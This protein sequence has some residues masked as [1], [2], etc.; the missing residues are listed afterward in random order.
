ME[1]GL[2]E[3]WMKPQVARLFHLQY[4][5]PEKEFAELIDHFYDLPFQKDKCIRIIAREGN[6]IIGFQ[7][8][9]YWPYLY[10]GQVLNSYQSGNSLVHPDHRGKG[11]FQKL[12][13]YL[14]IH[15]EEMKIDLLTG[16]PIDASIGSLLRNKWQNIFNLSWYL[17]PIHPLS[18]LLPLNKQ[19]L[20]K[21]FPETDGTGVSEADKDLIRID[22]SKAFGDWRR[23]HYDRENYFSFRYSE[24]N[25][26]CLFKLKIN[27][28][29]KVIKELIIG[30]V[31]TSSYERGF[32]TA[33]FGQLIREAKQV[34]CITLLTIAL[35]EKCANGLAALLPQLKFRK[36]KRDIYFCIKP[37]SEKAPVGSVD[38]WVVYRGDIDTW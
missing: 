20:R 12:L 17:L 6:T 27:L 7:S 30:D 21:R 15:R 26:E 16:F 32:L 4:G 24:N 2:Y 23:T 3:D 33:A 31:I 1:V 13:D 8:F 37:F 18:V 34:R 28:R 35:N 10:R 38:K 22:H 5:I 36:I 11:I 29:K 14:D 25:Q 19:E 9:F